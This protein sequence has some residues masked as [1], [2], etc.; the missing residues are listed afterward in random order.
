MHRFA[1]RAV[2]ALAAGLLYAVTVQAQTLRWAAQNDILTQ[3]PHSQNH[4]T[5]SALLQHSYEGLVRYTQDYQVEGALA[6][7]WQAVSPTQIRFFLRKGVKFHDGTPFT[8]DD[9]VFSFGR[10]NAPTSTLQAYVAGVQKVVK[11]DAH[12]V[13]F[14]LAA[15][16]PILTR[17][18]VEFRIM[19]KAWAEK[20]KTVAPPNVASREETYATRN[21]MGTGP[22]RITA[23]VPEQKLTL[24]SNPDWWDRANASNVKEVSYTPIK[25]DQTRMAALLSGEVDLVTDV[26]T[27]DVVKL[28]ANPALKVIEGN[29]V[30]TVFIAMDLGS[31]EIRNA[32]GLKANPFKDKRVRQAL[33]LAID[34]VGIQKAI[35]RGLSQP[36][37]LMVPPGAN[38]YD[39]TLDQVPA[40]DVAK[41]K[42]LMSEAGYAQGFELPFN[43]PNNRYVNDEEICQALVSM[44]AKIGV[45]AKLQTESFSTYT[46]KI[47]GF[48]FQ[49]FFYGWGVPT[50]DALYVLQSLVRTRS[51]GADGNYNYFRLSDAQLDGVIDQI[52]VETDAAKRASLVKTAVT[53]V[54]DEMFFI[55]IHYQ[56][57]P[58]AMKKGV[59]TVHRSDDKPE[60]RLTAVK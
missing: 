43:C 46:P 20:H 30:R 32:T 25:S 33:S 26:P 49:F 23:W 14:V 1:P 51:S 44:W 52:K 36:A 12:T 60:A 56:V 17:L 59:E 5:T 8:A 48:Q 40:A 34:R 28:R 55:P 24:V 31:D 18:L 7:R 54:R 38:G 37:A 13:D 57:R 42:A 3:D 41:A 21:S 16:N 22:Y 29:E 10:I 4:T 19:S 50:Y 39:K 15:P 35:M 2:L 27:Q 45:K 58:W 9:V 6:E 53:R 47:Q 11:V